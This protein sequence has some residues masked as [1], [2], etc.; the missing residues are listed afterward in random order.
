MRNSWLILMYW[1]WWAFW[2]WW[3]SSLV[4]RSNTFIDLSW[5]QETAYLL[6]DVTATELIKPRRWKWHIGRNQ[7]TLMSLLKVN[8]L[9]CSLSFLFLFVD[10]LQFF[11]WNWNCV[12]LLQWKNARRKKYYFDHWHHGSFVVSSGFRFNL[13]AKLSFSVSSW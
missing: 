7:S 13:L 6:S 5:E 4:W 1:P 9:F 12:A 8:W 3:I 2:K 10:F 11:T